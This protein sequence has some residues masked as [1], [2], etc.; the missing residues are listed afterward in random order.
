MSFKNAQDAYR[1]LKQ[2]NSLQF[3]K[4]VKA[5][6]SDGSYPHIVVIRLQRKTSCIIDQIDVHIMADYIQHHDYYWSVSL[7]SEEDIINSEKFHAL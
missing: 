6:Y 3:S 5:F 2:V 4:L 1:C 7:G